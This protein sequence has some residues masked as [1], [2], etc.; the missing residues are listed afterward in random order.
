MLH[1]RK[2]IILTKIFKVID[3][4]KK[5]LDTMAKVAPILLKAITEVEDKLLETEKAKR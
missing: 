5:A 2:E 4:T 3:I 1:G